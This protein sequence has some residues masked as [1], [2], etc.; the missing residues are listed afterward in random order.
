MSDQ[1]PHIAITNLS[2]RLPDGPPPGSTRPLLDSLKY[3][4]KPNQR[5]FTGKTLL[6]DVTFAVPQ[7]SMVALMG[8]SGAGK[9]TLLDVIACRKS[10]GSLYGSLVVDGVSLTGGSP[11]ERARSWEWVNTASAYVRQDDCHIAQLT[12]RE[13]LRYAVRLRLSGANVSDADVDLRVKEVM[14]T[15]GISHVAESMVGD[16]LTRGISGGQLK[17][18]SIGVEIITKPDIIF[19]DEPTS[20]LD[21]AIALEVM[22]S[23]KQ[24]VSAGRS[25]VCTIHQPSAECF[26][27][28]SDLLLLSAGQVVYSGPA[29]AA[30]AYFESLGYTFDNVSNPADFIISVAGGATCTPHGDAETSFGAS[31]VKTPSQLAELFRSSPRHAETLAHLRSLPAPAVVSPPPRSRSFWKSYKTLLARTHLSNVRN[32]AYVQASARGC[33]KPTPL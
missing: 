31:H 4:L 21:S 29:A 22:T 6:K 27:L 26:A 25:V 23:V 33:V 32:T 3:S 11:K 5:Q 1:P 18:L 28:F 30:P 20:G 15:L 14:E 8:P 10:H 13:T 16:S 19:L 24:L 9:S 12:V 2:Y 17:R 7:G